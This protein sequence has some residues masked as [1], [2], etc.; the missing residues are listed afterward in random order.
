MTITFLRT[1]DEALKGRIVFDN[2]SETVKRS[3]RYSF[4]I[5]SAFMLV[6]ILILSYPYDIRGGLWIGSKS[7]PLIGAILQFFF[8]ILFSF[9]VGGLTSIARKVSRQTAIARSLKRLPPEWFGSITI[10]IDSV[11]LMIQTPLT[12]AKYD[13]KLS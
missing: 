6:I 1:Y 9:L 8:L 13:W 3:R 4:Y 7:Y 2:S 10:T 5:D 11:G 12:M